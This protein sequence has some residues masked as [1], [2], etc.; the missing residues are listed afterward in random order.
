M[1]PQ[2]T[3]SDCRLPFLAT[4]SNVLASQLY[5]SPTGHTLLG[6]CYTCGHGLTAR[7]RDGRRASRDETCG[8]TR[9]ALY[10][11]AVL[12][13]NS[14]PFLVLSWPLTRRSPYPRSG[15]TLKLSVSR[16]LLPVDSLTEEYCI[17][18]GGWDKP[19]MWGFG[20]SA[21]LRHR[22]RT[23]QHTR[24]LPIRLLLIRDRV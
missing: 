23:T 21:T 16:R 14:T 10:P 5:N 9:V 24:L 6:E 20:G 17:R 11:N 19:Q 12:M 7:R 22:G 13:A 2:P 3:D 1:L 15:V 18:G 4:T 8:S